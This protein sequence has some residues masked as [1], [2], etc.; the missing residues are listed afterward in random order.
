MSKGSI[1][2]ADCPPISRFGRDLRCRASCLPRTRSPTPALARTAGMRCGRRCSGDWP[3]A[4]TS[5]TRNGF[6][7]RRCAG[8][9]AAKR[10]RDVP[11]RQARWALRDAIADDGKEP[12]GARQSLRPMD[13]QGSWP[14]SAASRRARHG[15]QRQ[16]DQCR[17]G[18][19]LTRT[20]SRTRC[21]SRRRTTIGPPPMVTAA[22]EKAPAL[23][24]AA[25][26][27]SG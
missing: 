4:R 22:N 6:A 9:S 11:R 18:W 27:L 7:I 24:M 5:T 2:T 25:R 8:S 14:P 12:V 23:R 13:R 26:S 3:D 1:S 10:P 21:S 19:P 16:P 20:H 15:F 17:H